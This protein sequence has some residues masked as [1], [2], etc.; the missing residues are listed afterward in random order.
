M[1]AMRSSRR[2]IVLAMLLSACGAVSPSASGGA[3][4]NFDPAPWQNGATASYEWLDQ[5]DAQIGASQVEFAL[6]Q[7]VWTITE[8][9]V[10]GGLDQTSAMRIDATTLAPL[11]ETKTITG[12]NT[13]IQ[14][15]TQ[16]QNGKVDI[17]AVVN[18][19]PRTASV[20]VPAN[21]IDNDQLLMTLSAL[22]FVDGYGASYVVVV[23]QSALKADTN[24]TVRSQ[25]TITVPLGDFDTWRVDIQ[26]GGTTQTAWYQVDAPHTLVQYVNGINRMVL[27]Q[28]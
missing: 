21:A 4:L 23:T 24:I 13:D 22:P 9:D 28:D 25:E 15:E 19:Q 10:I 7:G 3:P 1:R 14:L 5:S 12:A 26:S 18:G 27:T 6:S 20:D 11:G 8:T 2:L 17:Q 16:Y